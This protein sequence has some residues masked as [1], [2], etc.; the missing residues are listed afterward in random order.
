MSGSG[1]RSGYRKGVTSEVLYGEPVPEE[2]E[3]IVQVTAMRGSNLFEVEVKFIT[4]ILN[5]G[6]KIYI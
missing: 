3:Y 5:I 1:R 2:G 4:L 6:D